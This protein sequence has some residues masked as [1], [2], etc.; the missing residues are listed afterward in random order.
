[1]ASY[2]TV[3]QSN[4]DDCFG[5]SR[6]VVHH[7]LSI[8]RKDCMLEAKQCDH[9]AGWISFKDALLPEFRVPITV[10]GIN[11][12]QAKTLWKEGTSFCIPKFGRGFACSICALLVISP[13]VV[14][15]SLGESLGSTL[16]YVQILETHFIMGQ[17][18]CSFSVLQLFYP[19][20]FISSNFN[21]RN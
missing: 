16:E 5:R 14:E 6:A 19:K 13:T 11:T 10:E 1:M 8:Q 15:T 4:L 17:F 9:R 21:W 20:H 18:H 3:M 7:L 2:Q 12:G